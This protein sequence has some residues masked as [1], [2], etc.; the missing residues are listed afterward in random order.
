[1]R[2]NGVAEIEVFRYC[3]DLCVA[4][5]NQVDICRDKLCRIVRMV[6]SRHPGKFRSAGPVPGVNLSE[7]E[8]SG[9]MQSA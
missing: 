4:D 9:G 5:R 7:A 1:M 2:D 8:S 3:P 6:A